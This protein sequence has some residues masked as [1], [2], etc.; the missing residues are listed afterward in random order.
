MVAPAANLQQNLPYWLKH[1]PDAAAGLGRV[2]AA[3]LAAAA[4]YQ[5][6]VISFSIIAGLFIIV[7]GRVW[8]SGTARRLRR[9][10]SRR[11]HSRRRSPRSSRMTNWT[12]LG[13]FPRW[14][15]LGG[16]PGERHLDGLARRRLGLAREQPGSGK[17]RLVAGTP[18]PAAR[19]ARPAPFER[20]PPH[21]SRFGEMSSVLVASFAQPAAHDGRTGGNGPFRR[22]ARGARHG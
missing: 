22:L 16:A 13:Q 9:T 20:P 6:L 12:K 8:A 18:S 17:R 2:G 21:P 11:R 5:S 15:K 7:S 3:R 4:C 1:Q 10:R 19:V 14:I